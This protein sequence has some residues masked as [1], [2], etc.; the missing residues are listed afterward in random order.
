[1]NFRTTVLLNHTDESS[2][3]KMPFDGV[4][5]GRQVFDSVGAALVLISLGEGWRSVRDETRL[6]ERGV[7]VLSLNHRTCDGKNV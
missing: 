2:A 5:D 7:H 4:H 3:F 6:I 1:M